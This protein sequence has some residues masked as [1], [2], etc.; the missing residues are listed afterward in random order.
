MHPDRETE[1]MN[2]AIIDYNKQI[3]ELVLALRDMT[4]IPAAQP[5]RIPGHAERLANAHALLRRYEDLQNG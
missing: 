1:Y 2:A 5:T 4:P 3:K